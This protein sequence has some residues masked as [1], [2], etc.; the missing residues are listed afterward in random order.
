M[1]FGHLS[2]KKAINLTVLVCYLFRAMYLLLILLL[3]WSL[4]ALTG[5]NHAYYLS[6]NLFTVIVWNYLVNTRVICLTYFETRHISSK[7]FFRVLT[8][9]AGSDLKSLPNCSVARAS[10]R[11]LIFQIVKPAR[12]CLGH[13]GDYQC[14]YNMFIWTSNRRLQYILTVT[15]KKHMQ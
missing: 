15:R 3:Q 13:A 5:V 9:R 6:F 1:P 4:Y 11:T 7:N 14:L 8:E 10:I 2:H 12:C